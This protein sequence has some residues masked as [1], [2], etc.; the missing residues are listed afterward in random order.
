MMNRDEALE[1][2]LNELDNATEKFGPFNSAHEGLAVIQE[3]FEEFKS[4]VF[5]GVDQTGEESDPIDEAIQ[6]AAMAI[7]FL[8]D[9]RV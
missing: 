3:E 6:L 7:R 8:I 9:V 4:A 2:I 5:W 1:E